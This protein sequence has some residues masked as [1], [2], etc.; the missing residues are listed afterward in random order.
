MIK[1]ATWISA[2]ACATGSTLVTGKLGATY[3]LDNGVRTIRRDGNFYTQERAGRFFLLGNGGSLAIASH[4]A[5]D[6]GLCG[7]PSIALTDA[8][9]L[10]SHTN[11]FGA[12]ENFIKQLSLLRVGRDDIVVALS[13]S[14]KSLNMIRACE[15]AVAQDCLVYTFS[16]FDPDNLLRKLGHRNFYV[17]AK[18]YGIVQLAHES[19]LHMACDMEA[20]VEL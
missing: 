14:G 13:C 20:G 4:I 17:P 10:T 16:G 11:D 6:F 18:Q 3:S 19:I 15:W 1:T 12:S 9:A 8:V 2:L 7:W 5:T